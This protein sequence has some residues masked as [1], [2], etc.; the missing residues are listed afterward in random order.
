MNRVCK[1][2]GCKINALNGAFCTYLKRYVE[3][4]NEMMC[5]E[6]LRKKNDTIHR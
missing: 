5:N 2:C 6:Y 3:H 4:T 1:Q